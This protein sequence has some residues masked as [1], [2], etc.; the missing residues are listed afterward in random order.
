MRYEIKVSQYKTE[1]HVTGD[2]LAVSDREIRM[3][4][5]DSRGEKL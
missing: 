3:S 2:R 4:L 5:Y 1:R